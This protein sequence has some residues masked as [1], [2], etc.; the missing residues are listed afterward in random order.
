[1]QLSKESKEALSGKLPSNGDWDLLW[2]RPNGMPLHM[3][4]YLSNSQQQP[5]NLC[6]NDANAAALFPM[7][8]SR[9]SQVVL[10]RV[11]NSLNFLIG[12]TH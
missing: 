8:L 6:H 3:V 11:P 7:I 12:F 1:M 5:R 4:T 2:Q 10:L 9:K